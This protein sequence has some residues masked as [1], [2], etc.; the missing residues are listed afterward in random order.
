MDEWKIETLKAKLLEFHHSFTDVRL[1][2]DD[3]EISF[4]DGNP[5]VSREFVWGS[6][7]REL[8]EELEEVL[9]GGENGYSV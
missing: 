4:S 8:L 2:D 9:R 7:T 3:I 1:V 6:D 5:M